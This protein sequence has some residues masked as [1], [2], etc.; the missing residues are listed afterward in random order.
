MLLIAITA[1]ILGAIADH[2]GTKKIFLSGFVIIGVLS[3]ALLLGVGNGMWFYASLFYI[4]GRIG[5]AGGNIF[6][7]SLFFHRLLNRGF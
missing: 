7:D 4:L 5:F 2:S 3:T 1:P 6:Y